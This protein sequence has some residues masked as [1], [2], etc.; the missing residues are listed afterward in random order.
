MAPKK[1]KPAASAAGVAVTSPF[2]DFDLQK[3]KRVISLAIPDT[4]EVTEKFYEGNHWQDG[5]GW[6]GPTPSLDN[7][8]LTED[9]MAD[10]EE[11]FVSKNVIREMVK[12]HVRGVA[13]RDPVWSFDVRRPLPAGQKRTATE[14][15]LI[16]EVADAIDIWYK[17]RRVHLA[18]KEIASMS[19][20]GGK[21]LYRLYT[22]SGLTV[23]KAS[24]D[25]EI[26][27]V[28]RAKTLAEALEY[29]YVST[30]S[31]ND[32]VIYTDEATQQSL[33][34]LVYH[35]METATLQP[36]AQEVAEFTYLDGQ[37]PLADSKTILRRRE[38]T[39]DTQVQYPLG[40]RLTMIEIDRTEPL[41][42][43]Q[44][45]ESQKAL[46]LAI[47]ML[48]RTMVTAGFLE[49]IFL[50]AQMPGEWDYDNEG[51]RVPGSFKPS[52]H[53]TGAGTTAYIRGI[54]FDPKEGETKVKDPKVVFREPVDPSGAIK[55]AQ[56]HYLQM[57]EMG[58][59]AHIVLTGEAIVSGK[60]REQARA[61]YDSSLQDTK[62]PLEEGSAQLLDTVLAMAETFMNAPGRY[63]LPLR[64]TFRCH[65]YTGPISW[66]ER[67]QNDESV[68]AGTLSVQSA[69]QQSGNPDA[70]AEVAQ[71]ASER[72]DNMNFLSQLAEAFQRLSAGMP[73]ELAAEVL[74][75][76][77]AI[78]GK[79]TAALEAE[80]KRNAPPPKPKPAGSSSGGA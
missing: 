55:A 17:K 16:A 49:R 57:L 71:I 2:A 59:Q 63:T 46:N 77:Q 69:I 76:D 56:F 34:V 9:V 15:K 36:S 51:N 60:S 75:I 79:M 47:S 48:P 27:G 26:T 11:R 33:G 53:W 6:I 1:K 12:R 7:E 13:G 67:K 50:D 21:G 22:P 72:N 45:H 31:L 40:G 18:V 24:G 66:E 8:K 44:I 62:G 54:D 42:D 25:T 52:K 5:E 43:K 20:R 74:G 19:C 28:P 29:I 80:A 41:I 23:T 38:G 64:A 30:P 35:P 73:A 78:I 65:I 32:A 10:L 14:D 3:A 68:K 58:N 4:L 37:R 61:D 70:D 39:T